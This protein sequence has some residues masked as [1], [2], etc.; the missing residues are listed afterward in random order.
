MLQ[1]VKVGTTLSALHVLL[2]ILI[3]KNASESMR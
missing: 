2:G 3:Y 1:Q